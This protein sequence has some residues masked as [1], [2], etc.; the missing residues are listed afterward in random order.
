MAAVQATGA[1]L[2]LDLLAL[3]LLISPR[4]SLCK[5]SAA[6]VNR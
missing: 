2:A 3:E 4:G 1:S 6:E 5:T